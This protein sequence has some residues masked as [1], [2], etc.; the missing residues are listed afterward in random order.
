M[1]AAVLY[2]R[3]IGISYVQP[4][5]SHPVL[6]DFKL[7]VAAGEVV[8]ILG[9][10]GVGKSS[11]LRILAGLQ[12]PQAGEV[13][14]LGERIHGPHPAVAVAFQEPALLPWRSLAQNVSFGLDFKH[15]PRLARDER[16]RRVD[17]AIAAVGL[18]HASEQYPAQLSGGMAQRAALARCLA[19]QPRVLLLDE[20]FGAL[21]EVTRADMQRLLLSIVRARDTAVVLITHDID[22]ALLLSDRVL[23]LGGAPASTLGEWPVQLPQPRDAQVEALGA[24]RVDILKTLR[25]AGRAS[26][27]SSQPLQDTAHVHGR[28]DAYAS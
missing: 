3:D 16:Q 21:D 22:E 10:S 18:T 2:A 28:S 8:S 27:L 20:P 11:L 14:L 19:R 17:E 9:H 6:R 1:S 24:L 25:R 13:S 23:L 4:R 15:Q 12:A 26:E 5:Q 7:Q